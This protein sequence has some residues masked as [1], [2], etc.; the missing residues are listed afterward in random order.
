L[1]Q[2]VTM[3]DDD[4]VSFGTVD[5]H[6][7]TKAVQET[8]AGLKAIL[9]Q[10]D[11][12]RSVA[13]IINNVSDVP[14]SFAGNHFDSGGFATAPPQW[15]APRTSAAFGAQS[16]S[17]AIATGTEGTVWYVAP[18]GTSFRFHW[19][20]PW[21]GGTGSESEVTGSLGALYT[22]Y[23]ITGNG[24]QGA[25]MVFNAIQRMPTQFRDVWV[26]TGGATGLLGMPTGDAS[27]TPDGIGVFMEFTGTHEIDGP[28]RDKWS[29]LGREQSVLG[30]PV[31]D[32]TGTADGIALYSNFQHGS[33]YWLQ[34]TDTGP[35][36]VHGPIHD[37]WSALGSQRSFLGYPVSDEHDSA[38]GKKR[39]SQFQH[40]EIHLD[41]ATGHV[42]ALT[43]F[44]LIHGLEGATVDGGI[45]Q[46]G[47]R[48]PPFQIQHP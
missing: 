21:A 46:G 18:D 20:N 41:K 42:D 9:D 39:V 29:A 6:K 4:G 48:P 12:A 43:E 34:H 31:K 37:K 13:C 1:E 36:E 44:E 22:S 7:E 25:Q 26:R 45:R 5:I 14:L 15:I 30:Y 10:L 17:G 40:G 23:T 11:K 33:I 3:A 28:I 24:D 2:E 8:L 47:S 27:P 19:D 16:S 38:D 32:V 35:F